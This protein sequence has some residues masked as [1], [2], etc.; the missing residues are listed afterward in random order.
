M[1]LSREHFEEEEVFLSINMDDKNSDFFSENDIRHES[2][3]SSYMYVRHQLYTLVP[4]FTLQ[5]KTKS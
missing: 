4:L 5:V 3:I 2:L 1:A